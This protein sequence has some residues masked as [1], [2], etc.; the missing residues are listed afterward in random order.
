VPLLDLQPLLDLH[1]AL[2]P[3]LDAA[4]VRGGAH[5]TVRSA[6][7]KRIGKDRKYLEYI[8]AHVC[9]C[10]WKLGIEQLH[11]T[12]VA[13]VGERGLSQ[14]CPDREAIPLCTL[15]H[16]EGKHSVHK[17]GV[18]FWSFWKLDKAAVIA[19]LVEKFP[20]FEPGGPA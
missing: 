6:T 10:C 17:M 4:G 20:L 1:A 13:H 7:K 18:H 14:K 12:E 11:R 16:T 3:S 8:A 2:P 5:A 19:D 9:I 15:H